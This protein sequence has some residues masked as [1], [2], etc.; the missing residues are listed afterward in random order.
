LRPADSLDILRR[1]ARVQT[2]LSTTRTHPVVQLKMPLARLVL[3]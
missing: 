1:A 3:P 2:H